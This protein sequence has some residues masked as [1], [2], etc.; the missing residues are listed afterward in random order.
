MLGGMGTSRDTLGGTRGTINPKSRFL[1]KMNLLKELLLLVLLLFIV[2]SS[3]LLLFLLR[4]KRGGT[5][6]GVKNPSG[7]KEGILFYYNLY[8][9]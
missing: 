3:L 4:L 1:V 8:Y 2:V 7:K 5:R 6:K 9:M